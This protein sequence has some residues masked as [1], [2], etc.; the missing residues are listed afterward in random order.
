MNETIVT[1]DLSDFGNRELYEAGQLLTMYARDGADFLTEGVKVWFNRNSG[2]VFLSDE[3]YDGGQLTTPVWYYKPK[4]ADVRF[5]E[6]VMV[7]TGAGWC[8]ISIEV[9][10]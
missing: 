1:D 7:D 8:T 6:G 10:Q 2:C 9:L 3:D 4:A 5:I